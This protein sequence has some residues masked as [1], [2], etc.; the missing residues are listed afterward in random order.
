MLQMI[1][2]AVLYF[3]IIALQRMKD[4]GA[5][6]TT[7]ESIMFMLCRDASHPKFKEIQKLVWDPAPDS[8][9]LSRGLFDGKLV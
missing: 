8:G 6:I 2:N 9:L 1:H 4:A 7:S 5:F 3:R